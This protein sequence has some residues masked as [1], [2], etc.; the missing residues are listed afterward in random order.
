MFKLEV[1]HWAFASSLAI[2]PCC[3]ALGS[4]LISHRNRQSPHPKDEPA[5]IKSKSWILTGLNAL[6]TSLASLPM[7]LQLFSSYQV[8]VHALQQSAY[9]DCVLSIFMAY[10]VW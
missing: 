4:C 10:L 7:A 6:I 3:Y 8:D 5:L 9:S 2:Y 1:H